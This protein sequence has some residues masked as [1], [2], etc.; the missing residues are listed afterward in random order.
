MGNIMVINMGLKSVRC[1]IFSDQGIKLGSASEPIKTTINDKW[2]EQNPNEWWNKV[3]CV[4]KK[5]IKDAGIRKADFITVTASASCLACIDENGKALMPA[6]MVSDKRACDEVRELSQMTVFRQIREQTGLDASSSLMIPKIM[7][8]KK[9]RPGVFEKTM[10]FLSPNDYLVYKLCG[11]AVT[12]YLNAMKYHYIV[13]KKSY[14][15]DLLN[16]LGIPL[17]KLPE[18]E[19]TGKKIGCIKEYIADEVGI[20]RDTKVILASYDAICSFIGS[21]V[22]E[23]G[24]SSDVSGTVT[25]FRTLSRKKEIGINEEIYNVPFYQHDARILGGS[26]NLGGGLV[27]W[28]KQCYYQRE[29]YPYEIMEKDARESQVGA[30]GL[31]FLPYLLGERAPIWNDEARGVFFGL[32]RMHT[33][34]DMTRA[35]FESTGFIDMD[36]IEAIESTGVKVNTIRFSGGGARINLIAQIKADILNRDL[37]VLSEFETTATGAAMIALTGQGIYES[38]KSAADKFVMVRMIIKPNKENHKKYEY[39]YQLYKDTYESLKELFMRRA[40]I[41]E[42]IRDDREVKIENL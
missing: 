22:A 28:V 3:L 41:L 7:W 39:M 12:D 8:V 10:Y 36:F 30:R 2:V 1:I 24:D 17:S 13:E 35:V 26:N 23:E 38:I 25:V 6:L 20:T 29:E 34:K 40:E 21:G 14:P 31:I 27:E 16:K 15:I 33:R 37:F 9:N 5:A 19:L 32:E 11:N 18:V 4:M 42:K